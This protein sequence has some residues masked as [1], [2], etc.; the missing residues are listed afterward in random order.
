MKVTLAWEGI[1]ERVHSTR[2]RIIDPFWTG[3]WVHLARNWEKLGN[4]KY[5]YNWLCSIVILIDYAN[6][7]TYLCRYPPYN[8]TKIN[9]FTFIIRH[10][11]KFDV[12]AGPI[13]THILAFLIGAGI[14]AL[15]AWA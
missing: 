8:D 7:N 13:F 2:S 9:M 12:T 10:F 3:A 1:K 5:L 14:I 15:I 6:V 4:Y 11:L